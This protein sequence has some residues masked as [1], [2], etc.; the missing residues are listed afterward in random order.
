MNK[1]V[2]A[3]VSPLITFVALDSECCELS[4]HVSLGGYR[5]DDILSVHLLYL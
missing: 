4:I 3:R 2:N 1:I 5:V